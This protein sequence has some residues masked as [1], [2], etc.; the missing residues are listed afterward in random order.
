MDEQ[1]SQSQIWLE[2]INQQ[3]ASGKSAR[4]W[5]KEQGVSY[6]TFL[7]WRKR[8]SAKPSS[9]KPIKQS[10]FLE[11]PENSSEAWMKISF[12]GVRLTL[13]KDFDKETLNFCLKLFR[14]L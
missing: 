7:Y 2:K 3:E 5:C 9:T 8:L 14:D 11:L 4:T 10:F 6:Q 12:R 13:F 1:L